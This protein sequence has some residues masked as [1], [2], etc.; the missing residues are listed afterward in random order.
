MNNK[1][2]LYIS[3]N[4]LLE[5]ILLSQAVPYLKALSKNGFSFILLT[6]EKKND[7]GRHTKKELEDIKDGLRKEGI[8]W[9]WLRY[10]KYPTKLS[11]FFDILIGYLVSAYLIAANKIAIVHVRGAT[12]GIIGLILSKVFRFK[13]IFDTRGLLAEEYAGGGLWK[14]GSFIFKLVKFVEKKL[15]KRADAVVVLTDRHYKKI[16]EDPRLNI[17]DKRMP[18]IPCCVDLNRFKDDTNNHK[19]L[20]KKYNIE[21]GDMLLVYPGKVGTFYLINEMLEFFQYASG[22]IPGLNFLILTH[23]EINKIKNKNLSINSKNIY[24]I[25]PLF[26]EIPVFLRCADAGIFFIN[27]YKKFAS[28]PI[29]LGEF[30]ACGRPVIINSGIGDTGELV[31][32]NRV[33]VVINDFN[34]EE[35]KI[36]LEELS[37]LLK[38]GAGLSA[39]CRLTAEK[40]L[41]LEMG[42]N[43]Y[44]D[45]YKNI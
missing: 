22:M 14:E 39:R 3:Y 40:Y 16:I 5:P 1:K 34:R 29:K 37:G 36:K 28:S 26:D 18:I 21:H 27:P 44:L 33:G 2:A 4:G 12:P 11:T 38:E 6:F 20:L 30:L 31:N 45:M 32:S 10:H 25:N 7:L 41:S 8:D 43:R 15:L 35:Y 19:K 9:K 24:I 23:D 13:L 42:S 17:K